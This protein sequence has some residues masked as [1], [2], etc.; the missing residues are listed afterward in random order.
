MDES[1]GSQS[2]L[3]LRRAGPYHP[4]LDHQEAMA[5]D[6]LASQAF[7]GEVGFRTG[8]AHQLGD[9]ASTDAAKLAA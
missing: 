3:R 4:H 5:L 8:M 1:A 2:A 7:D 9:M 6:C